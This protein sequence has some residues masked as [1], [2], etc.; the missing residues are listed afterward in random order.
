MIYVEHQPGPVIGG[1]VRLLWYCKAPALPHARERI[2]PR[3]E[4]QIVVNLAGDALTQ[5]SEDHGGETWD[6]PSS[7]VVGARGRYDL[8]DTRDLEEL[9]GVVFWPGGSGAVLS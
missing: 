5:H 4:M 1:C 9:I 6:L 2:L 8:V 7:I 3:G